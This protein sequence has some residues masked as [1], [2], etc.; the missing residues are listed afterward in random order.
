M[1]MTHEKVLK[2]LESGKF[3]SV[4]L[5]HGDEPYFIDQ[6]CQYIEKNALSES[7]KAFNFI[8]LYGKDVNVSDVI[9]QAKQ[10]PMMGERLVIILKEAQAMR[11]L[12]ALIPYFDS[13][14]KST[15]LVL[16]HKVKAVNK[17]TKF[18]K[19]AKEKA[20]VMASN[21]MKDWQ[22][23]KWFPSYLKDNFQLKM[24]A[25]ALDVLVEFQGTEIQTLMN[26]IN[27]INIKK[28]IDLITAQMVQENIGFGKNFDV[29]EVQDALAT[30]NKT[31]LVRIITYFDTIMKAGDIIGIISI[32]HRYFSQAYVVSVSRKNKPE[33][34]QELGLSEWGYRKLKSGIDNY[35]YKLERVLEIIKEYEL[36]SKGV[37]SQNVAASALLKEMLFKIVTL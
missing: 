29:F 8:T 28:D 11:N 33:L 27:K 21:S 31:T 18:Y 22:L 1:E 9:G 13:P 14:S 2:E 16:A 34:F 37:N 35:G 5:L 36:K 6:V 19:K 4:Y 3:R 12:D 10:F 26:E 24:E 30:R 20:L 25:R 15:V 7:E 23:K 17:T 32:L